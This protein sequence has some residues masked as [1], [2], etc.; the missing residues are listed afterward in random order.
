[1]D[2]TLAIAIMGSIQ[3]VAVAL[4]SGPFARENKK[5]K[6]AHE[7]TEARAALRAEE[8]RLSMK[9][10]SADMSLTL[11]TAH[12]VKE[13]KVNGRMDAALAKAEE[14]QKEYYSFINEVAAKQI[15][16]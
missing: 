16:K 13:G 9:L 10:I 7:H 1:M 14:A 2:T 5:R 8:S 3:A 6:S 4:I 11:A 12:S 15:T